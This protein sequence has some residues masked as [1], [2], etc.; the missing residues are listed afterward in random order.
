MAQQLRLLR[1]RGH[2]NDIV[3]RAKDRYIY[4][5]LRDAREVSEKPLGPRLRETTGPYIDIAWVLGETCGHDFSHF[6]PQERLFLQAV[7][8][9]GPRAAMRRFGLSYSTWRNLRTRFKS[10]VLAA[11]AA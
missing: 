3:R 6:T 8:E 4:R 11:R 10:M 9:D 2:G 7:Y 5:A 1:V